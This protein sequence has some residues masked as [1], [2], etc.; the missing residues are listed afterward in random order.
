[1]IFD[2]IKFKKQTGFSLLELLLYIGLASTI[3]LV[4]SSFFVLTVK[5]KVKNQTIA[6][7]E[8]QGARV[9]QIINQKIHNATVL[10]SP[11]QGSM[12]SILNLNGG[13]TIFDLSNNTIRINEGTPINLI[14]DKVLVTNLSFHN[15]SYIDTPGIIRTQFTLVHVNSSGRNEYDYSQTFYGSANLRDN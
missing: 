10:T 11:S 1:M 14:S 13:T 2:N 12:A 4:T 6:E 7:V 9:M 3:L 15:L 5:S 8:Q